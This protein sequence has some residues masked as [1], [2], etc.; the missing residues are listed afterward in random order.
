MVD[1]E[2]K[3]S[4]GTPQ[5][6]R[7]SCRYSINYI[8]YLQDFADLNLVFPRHSCRASNISAADS[9]EVASAVSLGCIG[10]WDG[11]REAQ[12]HGLGPHETSRSLTQIKLTI[13]LATWHS[14]ARV[15]K[16]REREKE[17]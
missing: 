1:V 5:C 12:F 15:Q 2:D 8:A 7:L 10:P 14:I 11:T 17:T 13:P 4:Q 16:M 6:S 9:H 3:A